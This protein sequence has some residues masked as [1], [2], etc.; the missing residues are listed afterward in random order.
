MQ[1]DVIRAESPQAQSS[2][3]SSVSFASGSCSSGVPRQARSARRASFALSVGGVILPQGVSRQNSA[4]ALESARRPQRRGSILFD[5]RGSGGNSPDASR[6][7]SPPPTPRSALRTDRGPTLGAAA[8][9]GSTGARDEDGALDVIPN[10]GSSRPEGVR[11]GARVARGLCFDASGSSDDAALEYMGYPPTFHDNKNKAT[12]TGSTPRTSFGSAAGRADGGGSR[13]GARGAGSWVQGSGA[14]SGAGSAVNSSSISPRWTASSAR[15]PNAPPRRHPLDTAD[16]IVSLRLRGVDPPLPGVWIGTGGYSYRDFNS[17]PANDPTTQAPKRVDC[18]AWPRLA[19]GDQRLRQLRWL[20]SASVDMS[21][22][23]EP[24]A[25]ELKILTADRKAVVHTHAAFP[26]AMRREAVRVAKDVL[27]GEAC[28][29]FQI[30]DK[31][32]RHFDEAHG[33]EWRCFVGRVVAYARPCVRGKGHQHINFTIG[34]LQFLLFR[35]PS[36]GIFMYELKQS[37]VSIY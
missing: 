34:Q 7:P 32:T 4:F 31:L 5:L 9:V 3:L 15:D 19:A 30:A 29:E 35:A 22:D 12:G 23:P 16:T 26:R 1:Y 17:P 13:A 10:A 27:E 8:A 33:P 24:S 11:A 28:V 6:S 21:R 2:R 25:H 18:H 36:D 14:G 20:A 37:V